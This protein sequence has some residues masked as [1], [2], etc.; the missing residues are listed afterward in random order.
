[1]NNILIKFAFVINENWYLIIDVKC[2]YLFI[3]PDFF[4]GTLL[5]LK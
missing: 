1:M 4:Y 2:V 3:S 5:E